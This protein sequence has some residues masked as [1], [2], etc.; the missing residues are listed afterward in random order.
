MG[1]S[2]PPPTRHFANT[3]AGTSP[4][5]QG[6]RHLTGGADT[7][8]GDDVVNVLGSSHIYEPSTPVRYTNSMREPLAEG[9]FWRTDHPE[10]RVS[11]KLFISQDGGGRLELAGSTGRYRFFDDERRVFLG[12]DYR[13]LFTVA[14]CSRTR[15]SAAGEEW[16][17]DSVIEGG[18]FADPVSAMFDRARI[19]IADMQHWIG[20]TALRV[21]VSEDSTRADLKYEEPEQPDVDTAFGSVKVVRTAYWTGDRFISWGIR[22]TCGIEFSFAPRLPLAEILP[23]CTYVQQLVTLG[24][25]RSVKV[26]GRSVKVR[27]LFRD[28]TSGEASSY[29]LH[30]RGWDPNAT[31]L[32]R[33]DFVHEFSFFWYGD[34]GAVEG[35]S[36][37]LDIATEYQVSISQLTATI[38]THMAPEIVLFFVCTAAEAYERIAKG[39]FG[40][41]WGVTVARRSQLGFPA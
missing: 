7:W 36:R 23:Y 38:E 5:N 4:L 24:L 21:E 18:H 35:L 14:G 39:L 22:Q 1:S 16:R 8:F 29:K 9:Y 10:T 27:A 17:A 28:G 6:G 41:Q 26:L 13:R 25:G 20:E 3:L 31:D 11:G 15:G 2:R 19:E 40:F 34:V 12:E 37:W 32:D 30:R 33:E